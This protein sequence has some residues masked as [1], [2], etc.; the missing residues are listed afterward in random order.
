[1]TPPRRD[2]KTRVLFVIGLMAGGGAE[3]VVA[4]ILRRLDRARFCPSLLLI[5]KRGPFLAH[6]PVDVPI[7]DCGRHGAGGRIGWIRNF[8]RILK[9]EKPDV[10]VSFLWFPNA[11][12]VICRFL[13]GVRCRL[14]LSERLTI[15]GSREGAA[16]ELARRATIRFLYPAADRILPN[17]EAMGR[18]FVERYGIPAPKVAVIPNPVDIEAIRAR[19]DESGGAGEAADRRLLVAGMGRLVAQKGFDLLVR[20]L[21]DVR[22]AVRVVLLGEGPEERNLRDLAARMG[23]SDRV[24]FA[25]FVENPYPVLSRAA[26]FVLP[27]RYEGF[28]NVLVEAMALGLPCVAARCPTGPEEIVSDG[29]N[30][31]LVPVEDP[32]RLAAAIDRLAADAPLRRQLGD[33]ARERVKEYDAA[34]VVRRYESLLDAVT[35]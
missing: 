7:L 11:V 30:G 3:R 2:A 22:S 12:T 26:V 8:V 31:L 17:S 18:Q 23:V 33:A 9:R 34:A 13:S 10:V 24:D 15:D 35:S 29:V 20:A 14:I 1:M 16:A 28:P 6:V 21:A 25:G 5:E 32:K 4:G 27:S 19:G